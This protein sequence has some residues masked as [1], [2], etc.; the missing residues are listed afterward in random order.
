MNWLEC[1][2][3]FVVAGVSTI[4]LVPVAKRIAIHF[5]AIDYPSE[6]RV[7]MRPI[8]RMGG[9]AL[10]GGLAIAMVLLFLGVTFF[11][12]MNP[13]VG[14]PDL[15]VNYIGVILGVLLIFF[16]GAL[17][18]VLDLKPKPKLI[19]QV[20]A[21]CVVAASGVLLSDIRNPFGEGYIEFGWLAY[22]ITV[23]YLVAFANVINLIDGLD[24]LAAGITAISAATIFIFSVLTGRPDAAVMSIVLLGVCVGFLRYNFNPA[25]IFMGDSGALLL[26]FLLGVVSLFA[27]ARSALFVSLLVPILA[28]GVPIIDT[29]LAIIRR[30]RAHRPV[31]EADRGHIHHRLLEA[32]FTQRATVLIM[33]AWT[34]A[35]ALCA[36]LVT[37]LSGWARIIIFIVIAVITGYGIIKLRLLQ[38][39][40]LHHYNPRGKRLR[41]TKEQ[42]AKSPSS[43]SSDQPSDQEK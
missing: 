33:W 22:P 24:G 32:G 38:P 11:G 1:V 12:W 5:D 28:A 7:N 43:Q 37:E 26:G 39:V 16:V 27:V 6:R 23:F 4:L 18:D 30:K 19:G 35:L 14:H 31:D 13:F 8:P 36:V 17:D 29:A 25:S 21:A 20:V 9:I 3:L 40:L 15:E 10:L 42:T 41:D 2:V 34:A